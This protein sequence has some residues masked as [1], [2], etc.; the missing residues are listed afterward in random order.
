MATFETQV[1]NTYLHAEETVGVA[2]NTSQSV[3]RRRRAEFAS[4]A[5]FNFIVVEIKTAVAPIEY[6]IEGHIGRGRRRS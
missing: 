6:S 1:T 3:N 4:E 5:V 2:V